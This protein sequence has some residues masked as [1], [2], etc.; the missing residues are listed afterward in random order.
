ME[1]KHPLFSPPTPTPTP[2]KKDTTLL[3]FRFFGWLVSL[4][5]FVTLLS[6]KVIPV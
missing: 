1:F 3:G 6:G 2:K 4:N 5:V